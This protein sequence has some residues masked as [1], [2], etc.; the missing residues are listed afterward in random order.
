M[1]KQ[2]IVVSLLALLL[3]VCGVPLWAQMTATVKGTAKDRDGKPIE[4]AAV[5][6]VNQDT[7][8]KSELKTNAKGEYF[9]IGI[10]PGTYTF[11]LIKDG[12]VI[13]ELNNVPIDVGQERIVN[14]DLAKDQQQQTGAS[15]EEQKKVEAQKKESETIKSLNAS[16][17]QARELEKAGNYD[18]AITILEQATQAAPSKD[19]IWAYLGDAQRG[20][21]KYA[22]A[23][24]SYKKALALKPNAGFYLNGL[25]EAYAKSGQADKAVQEYAAAAEADPA[26]AG[27]YYFNEGAVFTNASK[28]DEAIAAFD[29][30]IQ[31]D[32]TRADA[33]YWKGINMVGKA[34]L[35]GGKMVAPEGTSEAFN[36]YLELQPTGQ[37][38]E[39]AKQML[40][41][42]GASV[43]TSYGKTKPK[44]K[45][46]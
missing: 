35:Q 15:E 10:S 21:K 18:Q 6:L 24:E 19:L 39:A 2:I 12:Q 23:V 25:A 38:A 33:Y 36:K 11:T 27:T 3:C 37:Y 28:V 14:F 45:K 44:K 29:K 13:D 32:P 4:N 30:A 41:S 26:H 43:E 16:L 46:P 20:A 1:K 5:R 8:R 9:S 17:A 7:G 31:I 22:E 40:A 42:I 34:T